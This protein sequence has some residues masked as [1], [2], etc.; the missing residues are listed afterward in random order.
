[1]Q[2]VDRP[3][4]VEALSLP[5]RERSPRVEAEAEGDV[6]VAH[7]LDRICGHCGRRRDLGQR[8]AIRPPE[9]ERAIRLSIDLIAL[10]V[11]RAVVPATE[12]REIRER[13]GPALR[14]VPDV[15]PLTE[16]H[17]AAR[18]AASPVP[19]VQRSPQRRRNRPGP[20]PDL[21]DAPGR[22]VRH[23]H[24]ARVARQAP[25]SFRGTPDVAIAT[26]RPTET[27]Y[28]V[29]VEEPEV[30]DV[31]GADE[32]DAEPDPGRCEVPRRVD[33]ARAL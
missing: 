23:H 13:R 6:Y 16:R 24:P 32:P 33:T 27:P 12:Q 31:N 10:F 22:V 15:M 20:G 14:P 19:M 7:D 28:A 11:D 8:P 17:A 30:G 3:A 26:P 18:E 9:L 5:A 4:D 29:T 2:D 21:H 1:M 25:H